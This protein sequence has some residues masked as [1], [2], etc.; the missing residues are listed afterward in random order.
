MANSFK[1][2]YITTI[3][4]IP[5]STGQQKMGSNLL[6]IILIVRSKTTESLL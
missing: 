1:H 6:D 4:P 2:L 3:M 5:N